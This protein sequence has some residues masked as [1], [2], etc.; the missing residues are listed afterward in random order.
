MCLYLSS[1]KRV[2]L[3]L[4]ITKVE[5]AQP[6]APPNL[7]QSTSASFLGILSI[8]QPPI[9]ATLILL[10]SPHIP[11]PPP[12]EVSPSNISHLA[13]DDVEWP[14]QQVNLAQ[15]LLFQGLGETVDQAWKPVE[16]VQK[17]KTPKR[18]TEIGEGG[19]YI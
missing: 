10:P 18:T 19:M 4:F 9:E 7:I 2:S 5:D 6:F 3:T 16:T 15:T 1:N 17:E 13:Q 12:K 11:H 8:A 14:T